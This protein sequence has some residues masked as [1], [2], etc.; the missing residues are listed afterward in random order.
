MLADAATPGEWIAFGT[1][2]GSTVDRCTCGGGSPFHAHEYGCGID[3]P[4]I[5]GSEPDIAHATAWDPPTALLVADWLDQHAESH[6]TY[7]C[8]WDPCRALALAAHILGRTDG[9]H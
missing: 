4:I 8:G 1:S 2:I 5:Q 7:D 6:D 3:G 9:D